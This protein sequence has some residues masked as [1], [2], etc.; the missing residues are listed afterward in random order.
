MST[1]LKGY[2]MKINDEFEFFVYVYCYE[3]CRFFTDGVC[4][5]L[6]EINLKCCHVS[7][8]KEIA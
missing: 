8:I 7:F 4:P 5:R 3:N 1:V 2:L 6:I